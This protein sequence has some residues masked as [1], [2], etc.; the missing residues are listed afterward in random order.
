MRYAMDEDLPPNTPPD[1]VIDRLVATDVERLRRLYTDP[2]CRQY[3][4]GPVSETEAQ[5]RVDQLLA[6]DASA[7]VWAIRLS[8][9]GDAV[10]L[11]TLTGHHDGQDTELSYQ[12]LPEYWGRGIATHAVRL[13]IRYA[14][15]TLGL[16]RLV[17]ETQSANTASIRLL[18]RVGMTL[19]RR[20]MRFGAEQ[21]IYA[22]QSP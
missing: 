1:C 6:A 16:T 11:L 8:P 2:I 10:G 15:E 14:F 22:I 21:S 20:V 19:D 4:G 17:S 18:D 5:R 3:L 7:G 13:A 9:S 12:L